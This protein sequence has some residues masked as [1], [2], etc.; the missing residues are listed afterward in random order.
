MT[1]RYNKKQIVNRRSAFCYLLSL[2]PSSTIMSN[3]HALF[4]ARSMRSMYDRHQSPWNSRTFWFLGKKSR[5]Y[6]VTTFSEPSG[7]DLSTISY[8]WYFSPCWW[9]HSFLY[10]PGEIPVSFLNT[11]Q[12]Y[13]R[14]ENPLW[15]AHSSKVKKG[16]FIRFFAFFILTEIKYFDGEIL[17]RALKSLRR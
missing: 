7:L 8:L 13:C 9:Y 12:K 1:S 4:F 11:R 6:F 14:D 5:N 2:C 3:R 17:Y 10:F 15:R 16:Y